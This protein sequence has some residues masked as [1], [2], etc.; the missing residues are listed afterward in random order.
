M[1]DRKRDGSK[2]SFSELDKLRRERKHGGSRQERGDRHNGGHAQKSYR[3]ALERAF[4]SGRLAEFAATVQR[5]HEDLEIPPRNSAQEPGPKPGEPGEDERAAAPAQ[6]PPEPA[7]ASGNPA[8]GPPANTERAERR[9]HA[10]KILD[11]ESPRDVARAVDRYLGRFG[12]LPGDYDVLERALGHPK[13]GVVLHALDRL[14]EAVKKHKPRRSRSLSVQLSI[15]EDT[16]DDDD[17]RAHAARVRA[18]L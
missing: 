6:S 2:L 4:D 5:R 9:R 18:A 17:V 13:T 15:L 10:K 3:A 12:E 1:S 11:A 16:H 14:E 7:P 8:A